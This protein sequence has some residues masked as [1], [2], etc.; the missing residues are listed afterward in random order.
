MLPVISAEFSISPELRLILAAHTHGG[1]VWIPI[2]GRP[3]I[4]SGYGQKYAYGHIVD[5]GMDM[6]V[7]SGIGTS[8]LPIR[9][10]V[11]PEIAVVTI[12]RDP[13]F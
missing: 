7:T 9:F 12:K 11:P 4:P 6:F 5:K 2:L 13:Q 3:I 10:M 8:V 1:Q